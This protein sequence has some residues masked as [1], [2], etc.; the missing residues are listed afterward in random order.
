M[1]HSDDNRI[2]P[3]EVQVYAVSIGDRRLDSTAPGIRIV[4][5]PTNTAVECHLYRNQHK[6]KMAALRGLK[7]VLFQE[8]D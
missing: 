6:N 1:S 3:N 5:K 4:H 8:E 2:S 7:A